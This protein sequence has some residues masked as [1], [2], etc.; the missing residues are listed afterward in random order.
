MNSIQISK[1]IKFC[2]DEF[3]FPYQEKMYAKICNRI[4]KISNIAKK[5]INLVNFLAFTKFE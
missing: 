3:T 5:S 1:K 2:D 4:E